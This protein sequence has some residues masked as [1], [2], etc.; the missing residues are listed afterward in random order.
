MFNWY[1][2]VVLPRLINSEMGTKDFEAIR[3]KILE[4]ASGAV[5]EIGVGPG[6]NIPHYKNISK[7]YALDPSK[8]LIDIARGRTAKASFPVEF[9]NA[10]A[11]NIPLENGSVDTVLSTWTL[12]SV[13]NPEKVLSEIRRVLRPNG[14]FIFSDH[15]ASPNVAIKII[16]TLYTQVSKY[17]TG[18]CHCDRNIEEI[19]RSS[20]L[21]ME[22][23]EKSPEKSRPMIY[24]YEGIAMK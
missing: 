12:C 2:R 18:N 23:I 17:F 11:E 4:E 8:E 9:L 20:G 10:E 3:G 21:K 16:Q 1:K 6:H 13:T 19:V 24:N 7:L 15:G 14:R 22:K 5:L